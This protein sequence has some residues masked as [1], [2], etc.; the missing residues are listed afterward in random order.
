[1]SRKVHDAAREVVRVFLGARRDDDVFTRDTIDPPN[2]QARPLLPFASV[3][4]CA[5]EHHANVV[6]WRGESVRHLP[7]P[8]D[9]GQPV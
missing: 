4:A 6:P 5:A 9:A 2:P 3:V 8:T 1:V 7:I